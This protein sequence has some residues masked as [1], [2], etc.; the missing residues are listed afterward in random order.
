MHHAFR[1]ET[2]KS[3]RDNGRMT[4][5]RRNIF[6]S[7]AIVTETGDLGAEGIKPAAQL[8]TSGANGGLGHSKTGQADSRAY[9]E[10]KAAIYGTVIDGGS[11]GI[12]LPTGDSHGDHS[13]RFTTRGF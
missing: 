10:T 13:D 7:S 11:A 4:V 2:A 1:D 8:D 9:G 12:A 5:E 6:D 3:V